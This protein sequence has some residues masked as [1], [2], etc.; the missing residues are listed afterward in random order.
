MKEGLE[1]KDKKNRSG[2]GILKIGASLERPIRG[3][4]SASLSTEVS[5]LLPSLEEGGSAQTNFVDD[6][7]LHLHGLMKSV[8]P[9]G[10]VDVD[11]VRATCDLAK[12]M[13]S[14]IRLKLD[15]WKESRRIG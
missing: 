11:K 15:M 5:S 4:E 1:V 12:E 10:T 9:K 6:C 2:S 7:C 8:A 14:L 13:T 3:G